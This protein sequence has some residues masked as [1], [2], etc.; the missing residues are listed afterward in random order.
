MEKPESNYQETAF[1]KEKDGSLE[2]GHDVEAPGTL[3][4]TKLL[5]NP[6][7]SDDPLDPLNWPMILKVIAA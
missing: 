1:Q 6:R 2:N 5:L 3:E 7:P 4:Q